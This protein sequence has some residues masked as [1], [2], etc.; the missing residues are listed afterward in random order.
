M[1]AN[2]SV[3]VGSCCLCRQT[4]T[5]DKRK[6]RKLH[7]SSATRL[8]QQL[9]NISRVPLESLLRLLRRMPTCVTNVRVV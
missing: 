4:L 5:A 6:K 2:S 9:Q 8:K 7:H 1:A 3:G